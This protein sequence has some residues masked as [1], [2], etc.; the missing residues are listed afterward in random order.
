MA[1][2]PIIR[3]FVVVLTVFGLISFFWIGQG[4]VENF[5]Q[6]LGFQLIGAGIIYGTLEL[7]VKAAIISIERRERAREEEEGIESFSFDQAPLWMRQLET[8]RTRRR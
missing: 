6:G 5:F 1:T 3:V 4:S 8:R 7:W 2:R